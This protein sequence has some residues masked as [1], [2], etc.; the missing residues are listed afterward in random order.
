MYDPQYTRTF[1]NACGEN[2]WFRLEKTA[3]GRLQGTIHTDWLNYY[4]KKVDRVLDAGSGP[5]RFSIAAAQ[6]G[7]RV[8]VLDISDKQIEIARQKVL[9]AA[10]TD[11]VDRFIVGDVA[12]LSSVPD[13]TFDVVICYGGALSYVCEKR[14]QAAAE[15]VRVT[16]PGG[17]LLISVMSLLGSL[18]GITRTPDMYTLQFPDSDNPGVPGLWKSLK[19]GDLPGFPSRI[20]MQHAPMHLYTAE[21]LKSLF[22]D[23]EILKVAGSNVSVREASTSAERIAVDPQ[24]WKTLVEFER[25][26]N[27]NSGLVNSGSH[28]LMAIKRIS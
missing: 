4:V 24:A 28:I 8:T 12:D 6:T 3:Y 20:G 10:L 17:I 13:S 18:L 16:R 26:I 11:R 2:E 1:Y 15:L 21:E 7:A 22:K 27:T 23:Q 9:E 25:R 19:T 5:G 14:A